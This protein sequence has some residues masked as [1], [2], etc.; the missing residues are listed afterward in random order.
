MKDTP[1][2]EPEA[3]SGAD[4]SPYGVWTTSRCVTCKLL[5]RLRPEPPMMPTLLMVPFAWPPTAA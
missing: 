2:T 4:G 1:L 3:A 5:S